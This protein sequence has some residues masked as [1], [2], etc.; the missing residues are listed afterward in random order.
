MPPPRGARLVEEE[1]F[2]T[3]EH[4]AGTLRLRNLP[5][6]GEDVRATQLGELVFRDQFVWLKY[7]DGTDMLTHINELKMLAGQLANQGKAVDDAENIFA[8]AWLL[9]RVRN[10]LAEM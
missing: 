7:K 8:G 4:E 10:L 2:W 6:S 9:G 5:A 1:Y 3:R